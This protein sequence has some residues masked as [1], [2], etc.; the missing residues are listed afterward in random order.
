MSTAGSQGLA[1]A[2]KREIRNLANLGLTASTNRVLNLSNVALLSQKD[3]EY[4]AK[5]FFI[6]ASL[7]RAIFVKHTLRPSER[8]VFSRYR[9]TATKIIF[10]YDPADLRIGGR[11]LFV[12]QMGYE[13]FLKEFLDIK[14]INDNQDAQTLRLMDGLPS[15]DPFLLREQLARNNIRPA[16]CYLKISPFDIQRMVGFA[17][18]EIERL[19]TTAFGGNVNGASVKLAGKILSQEL[20]HELTPLKMTLS[21][22]DEEFSDGIFSW[23]GFLYFKWRLVDLQMEMRGVLNGISSFIPEGTAD[24]LVLDYLREAR[25]RLARAIIHTLSKASRTLNIYD[26]AYHALNSDMNPGPFRQFLLDGPELFFDLGESIGVLGHIASFWRYRIRPDALAVTFEEYADILM[27]FEEGLS[28]N[29][30][31]NVLV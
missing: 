8:E 12:G 18:Q 23:R 27:D 21:M 4:K 16:A 5:P 25:P 3:P 10:P 28:V 24:D 31:E 1:Q 20:D 11:S 19:V 29:R 13:G 7:N 6:N 9:R 2:S 14:E 26:Q 17:N 22:S 15:L 30:E